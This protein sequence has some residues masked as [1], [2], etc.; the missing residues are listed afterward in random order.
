VS[1]LAPTEDVFAQFPSGKRSFANESLGR[2]TRMLG[3][4]TI[5]VKG[6]QET[7]GLLCAQAAFPET[8]LHVFFVASGIADASATETETLEDFNG[9]SFVL[10]WH[11]QGPWLRF[12]APVIES[13]TF[14]RTET[15]RRLRTEARMIEWQADPDPFVLPSPQRESRAYRAFISLRRALRLSVEEAAELVGV[16]RTT[17]ITSWQRG[18][19]EPQPRKARRLFQIESMVSSVM[20]RLGPEEGYRWLHNGSP[21]P[22]DLMK[23]TDLSEAAD[24]VER[25]LLRSIGPATPAAGSEVA[26]VDVIPFAPAGRRRPVAPGRRSRNG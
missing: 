19:H 22:F 23:G 9:G 4:T 16:G 8:P 6:S 5:T 13:V 24:V 21:S 17:P 7:A 12:D 14:P 26:A 11:Q 2:G 20:S 10:R 1:Q 15:I 18:G 3:Y 25:L